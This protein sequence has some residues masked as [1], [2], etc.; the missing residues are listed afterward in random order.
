MHS[1]AAVLEDDVGNN[2][3]VEQKALELIRRFNDP[4][5]H[6]AHA[7][8]GR[9][10]DGLAFDQLDDGSLS[11]GGGPIPAMDEPNLPQ[12]AAPATVGSSA[13][14]PTLY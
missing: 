2:D 9:Q 14:A 7:R 4:A 6:L 1:S 12:F 10:V 13:G 8:A 3:S 11:H 5:I